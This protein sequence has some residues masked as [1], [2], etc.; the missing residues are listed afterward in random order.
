MA[1]AGTVGVWDAVLVAAGFVDVKGLV[2]V[3]N[4]EEGFGVV[5][6]CAGVVVVA[7]AVVVAASVD[8]VDDVEA[9]DVFSADALY[10]A[11]APTTLAEP[12]TEL[13]SEHCSP[14]YVMAIQA[15]IESQDV[16][17]SCTVPLLARLYLA[18]IV[19]PE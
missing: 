17:Q 3:E 2:R 16:M 7:A 18:G 1:P 14:T 10:A 11:V 8:G 9:V 4:V 6:G 15:S 19:V 5:V 12:E 13:S